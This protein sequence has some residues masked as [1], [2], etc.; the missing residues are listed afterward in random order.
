MSNLADRIQN[1]LSPGSVFESPPA[2]ALGQRGV[3]APGQTYRI[4]HK[5]FIL[6]RPV[7]A[8][9]RCKRAYAIA[10]ENGTI[11]PDDDSH[12]HCPHNDRAEYLQVLQKCHAR[13][14]VIMHWREETLKNGVVQASTTWGVPEA[15]KAP[16]APK[17]VPNL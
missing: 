7:E 1:R 6:H 2:A 3:S 16:A 13:E 14:W 12:A 8:C 17:A 4:D 9:V 10:L 5:V 15:K 11:D